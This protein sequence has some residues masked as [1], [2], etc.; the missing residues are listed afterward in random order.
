MIVA[1]SNWLEVLMST[2]TTS[3]LIKECK[4]CLNQ[5]GS[6]N[7][8]LGHS[9]VEGNEKA[10]EIVRIGSSMLSC[11]P[12][13][14]IPVPKSLYVRAPKDWVKAKHVDRWEEYEGGMHTKCFFLK[15]NS[16][17]SKKLISLD[18]NRIRR[19]F[20]GIT[21]HYSLNAYY[22]T[23]HP[24][25]AISVQ[26]YQFLRPLAIRLQEE[27]FCVHSSLILLPPKSLKKF[28]TK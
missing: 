22:R 4:G 1:V 15:P 23:D 16:Q 5:M 17:W 27:A 18:R 19:M 11:G 10:D 24:P 12:E 14:Q 7:L 21:G 26:A 20:G 28:V 6:N 3:K 2:V 8:I 25:Y 9:G 13:P